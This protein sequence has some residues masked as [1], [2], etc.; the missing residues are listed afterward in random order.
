MLRWLLWEL[1][2]VLVAWWRGEGDLA[3]LLLAWWE[4][5]SGQVVVE[6]GA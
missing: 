4:V 3:G 5:A 6:D 1:S 2:Q